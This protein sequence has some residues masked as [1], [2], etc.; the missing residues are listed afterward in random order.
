MILLGILFLVFIIWETDVGLSGDSTGR[1]NPPMRGK[2]RP[3]F[4][5]QKRI[6]SVPHICKV[7]R[8]LLLIFPLYYAHRLDIDR[9]FLFF[10]FFVL[11]YTHFVQMIFR[12]SLFT[13]EIKYNL[14]N[15]ITKGFEH[16]WIQYLL[17]II[18][19]IE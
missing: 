6:W 8:L 14:Y 4:G 3:T 12:I 13:Y 9:F 2:S 17:Q 10:S 7:G 16:N 15:D 1:R 19:T 18:D 5:T 11:N